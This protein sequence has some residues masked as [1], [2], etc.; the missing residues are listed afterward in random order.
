MMVKVCG[1]PGCDKGHGRSLSGTASVRKNYRV[2]R[3]ENPDSKGSA[4]E[5][6]FRDHF[7]AGRSRAGRP[8]PLARYPP[9][10]KGSQCPLWGQHTPWPAPLHPRVRHTVLGACRSAPQPVPCSGTWFSNL[11]ALEPRGELSKPLVPGLHPRAMNLASLRWDF[12]HLYLK[13][14]KGKKQKP[15]SRRIQGAVMGV[16]VLAANIFCCTI[17]RA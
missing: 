14:K 2:C 13:K 7:P 11:A 16:D 5:T 1:R 17:N 8:F 10:A 4:L 6:A 3:Y 12:S 9:R 15:S